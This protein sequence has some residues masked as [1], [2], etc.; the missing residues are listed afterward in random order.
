MRIVKFIF[1]LLIGLL[2]TACPP[3][4]EISG[5]IDPDACNYDNNANVADS[6]CEYDSCTGCMDASACNYDINAEISDDSCEY[7]S[8]TGCMDASAC[9]YN[10]NA[11]LS[12][13][14]F[15]D[16]D[17]LPNPI[18]VTF[19]EE[20]VSGSIGEEIIAHIHIRNSS[21]ENMN[22]LLVRK[23]FTDPDASAYFCFNGICFPSS[24]IT[25]PNPLSLAPFEEDDYFKSYLT[26]DVSGTFDVT[27]RFYLEGNSTVFQEVTISYQVD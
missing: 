5:C 16:L 24:T 3:E 21:C 6:S 2:F 8:C 20:T 9:N 27:Y 19:I 25:S 17:V 13:D 15:Y 26:A 12:G 23:F 10:P 11:T 1:I 22:G 7:D 14:C 4:S 18:E